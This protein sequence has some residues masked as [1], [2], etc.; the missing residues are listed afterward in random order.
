MRFGANYFSY[1]FF[2]LRVA[3]DPNAVFAYF[4]ILVHHQT[5]GEHWKNL[6]RIWR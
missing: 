1:F 3:P 6:A 2:W 5:T 4:A